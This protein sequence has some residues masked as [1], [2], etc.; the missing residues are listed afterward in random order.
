MAV[1]IPDD[2]FVRRWNQ[3]DRRERQRLRRVVRL[4]RR[5]ETRD[6]A[7]LA[8][9][10]AQFQRTR[11]WSRLFWVWFVPGLVI[12]LGI[13]T[14]IHPVAVGI[15]LALAGQAVF[16]RRNLRRAETVNEAL[17]R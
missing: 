10:Y 7:A 9:G 11:I 6:E 8:V 15:V 5:L 4:G 12:A 14:Q 3:L 2:S 17:L 16:A 13:A 1:T